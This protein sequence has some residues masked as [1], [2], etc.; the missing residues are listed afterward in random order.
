MKKILLTVVLVSV[1]VIAS[2]GTAMADTIIFPYI[3]E[4]PGNV[5][6]IIS[7]INGDAG[8]PALHYR[9]ITKLSTAAAIDTCTE[10]DFYRPTSESDI[11]TFDASGTIG[12]GQAL[13]GD[14]GAGFAGA[15]QITYGAGA[16]APFFHDISTPKPRRGY[17]LVTQGLSITGPDWTPEGNLDG[18]A[19]LIDIVNG[20]AWGYRAGLNLTGDYAFQT[21]TDTLIE[22]GFAFDENTTIY[23]PNQFTTRYFVTPLLG[24]TG[25]T[26]MTAVGAATSKRTRIGLYGWGATVGL[27]GVFDRNEQFGSGGGLVHV[28]CVAAVE[29]ATLIGAANN[30]WITPTGGWATVDL[31]DPVAIVA[32]GEAAPGAGSYDAFVYDLKYGN[33]TGYTGMIND[34]KV[35]RTGR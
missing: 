15:F 5:S 21:S 30:T 19:M 12:S 32:E 6:T 23:A 22:A 9:Y 10:W 31:A 1:F 7:V 25:N 17:L 18:E 29:L 3:N 28:R 13:F 35:T 27:F 4:N 34:G 20:A 14:P 24:P 2:L 26:N 33:F 16:N 11:V 8:I